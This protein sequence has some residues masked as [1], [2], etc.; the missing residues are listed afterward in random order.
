MNPEQRGTRAASD[1]EE[2]S[3]DSKKKKKREQKVKK[4]KKKKGSWNNIW[5]CAGDKLHMLRQA[6]ALRIHVSS[7][8]ELLLSFKQ[9]ARVG[10]VK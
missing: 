1:T 7:R 5:A 9:A 2:I 3:K 8:F 10:P 4:K 6:S